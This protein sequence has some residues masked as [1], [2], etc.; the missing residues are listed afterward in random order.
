MQAIE[1]INLNIDL[2][3]CDKKKSLVANLISLKKN[4]KINVFSLSKKDII[5]SFDLCIIATTSEVRLKILKKVLKKFKIKKFVLEKILC[6][7]INELKDLIKLKNK[8]NFK[9]WI[10]CHRCLW[11]DYISL[12]KKINTKNVDNFLFHVIGARWN[13]ASNSIHF[14]HL[15]NFLFGPQ[16]YKKSNFEIKKNIKWKE[17]KRKNFFDFQGSIKFLFQNNSKIIL[18]DVFKKDRK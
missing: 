17:S 10:S 3:L 16:N 14:M 13:I 11:S 12:K 7:S 1:N 2:Y 6:Q 5:K 4:K 15:A 8:Y 9:S 18:E